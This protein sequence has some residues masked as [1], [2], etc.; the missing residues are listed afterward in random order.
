MITRV[1]LWIRR[2]DP[3]E[4]VIFGFL[5]ILF[6]L[7]TAGIYGMLTQEANVAEY[8]TINDLKPKI[9]DKRWHEYLEKNIQYYGYLTKNGH[10]TL[11]KMHRDLIKQE[12]LSKLKDKP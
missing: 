2:R 12:E 7:G 4:F 1:A 10:D 11:S 9:S 8:Q 6:V 5:V 3:A